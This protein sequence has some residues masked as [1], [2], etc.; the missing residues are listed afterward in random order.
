[1]NVD[2]VPVVT[3]DPTDQYTLSG[4]PPLDMIMVVPV[5]V[6]TVVEAMKIHTPVVF[7]G[8]YPDSVNVPELNA[9]A[10]VLPPDGLYTPGGRVRPDNSE[11]MGMEDWL[12]NALRVPVSAV[13]VDAHPKL[14]CEPAPEVIIV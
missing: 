13:M 3:D 11:L 1:M 2:P 5:D 14:G 6:V 12:F 7:W 10:T 9:K 4:R 8:P